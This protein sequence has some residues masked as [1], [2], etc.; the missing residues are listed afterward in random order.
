[1]LL[2]K[3]FTHSTLTSKSLILSDSKFT[4]HVKDT[5]TLLV[6]LLLSGYIRETN[7]CRAVMSA[8]V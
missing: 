4:I 7:N 5:E 2:F 1:M 6:T 8:D 3:Y